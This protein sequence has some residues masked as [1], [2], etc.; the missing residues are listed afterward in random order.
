MEEEADDDDEALHQE[1]GYDTV[2]VEAELVEGEQI[3]LIASSYTSKGRLRETEA[4]HELCHSV[5][6]VSNLEP[7]Q[8]G[9]GDD[10]QSWFYGHIRDIFYCLIQFYIKTHPPL[11]QKVKS[12]LS[13]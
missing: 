3:L 7:T 8:E 12:Q 11:V 2:M 13:N 10:E 9:H 6:D 4:F 1:E 5:I